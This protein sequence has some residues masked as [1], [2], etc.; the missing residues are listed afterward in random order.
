MKAFER[1]FRVDMKTW[2]STLWIFVTVNYIFCDVLSIMDPE[3]IKG[4]V[5]G[6]MPVQMTQGAR[7]QQAF[8]WKFLLS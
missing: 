7:W 3:F 5:A 8:L 6:T 2:L 1:I 4:I